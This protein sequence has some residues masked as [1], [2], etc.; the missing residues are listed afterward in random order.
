MM[1][2]RL[3]GWGMS[4]VL[5][6]MLSACPKSNPPKPVPPELDERVKAAQAAFAQLAPYAPGEQDAAKYRQCLQQSG[7]LKEAG[8]YDG[9]IKQAKLAEL[10]AVRLNGE[11]VSRE[12]QKFNPPLSTTYPYRQGLKKSEDAEL[13]GDLAGALAGAQEALKLISTALNS[14]GDCLKTGGEDLADLKKQLE[15][16]YLPEYSLVLD[17]WD[18]ADALAA[19]NCDKLNQAMGTVRKKIEIYKRSTVSGGKTFTV[20]APPE[21]LK[22]YGQPYLYGQVTKEGYLANRIGQVETGT[23]VVFVRCMLF[24]RDK[25]FYYV[26]DEK[27]GLEGWVAEERVWPD[28][29]KR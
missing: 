7:K 9:A 18:A 16:L 8:D 6:L 20:T 24:S 19:N 27:G 17:F 21:Y 4:M 11:L 23:V 14:Q 1:Q 12:L 2:V 10:A 15:L 26:R 29:T 5:F 22:Q 13:A 28:R 3:L 25:T